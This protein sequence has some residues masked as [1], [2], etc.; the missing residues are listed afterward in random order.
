MSQYRYTCPKCCHEFSGC[1]G[2]PLCAHEQAVLD[3]YKRSSDKDAFLRAIATRAR[4]DLRGLV[5]TTLAT[6]VIGAAGL[7][8]QQIED[9]WMETLPWPTRLALKQVD[10]VTATN[11]TEP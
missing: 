7:S 11:S 6:E 2:S 9:E 4:D 5:R 8:A 10:E 3:L 1:H